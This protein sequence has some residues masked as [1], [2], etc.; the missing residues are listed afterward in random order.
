MGDHVRGLRRWRETGSARGL[1]S[2]LVVDRAID[3]QPL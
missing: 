3:R 2:Q 1:S